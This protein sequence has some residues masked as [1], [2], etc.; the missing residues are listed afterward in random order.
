MFD[1]SNHEESKKTTVLPTE[2]LEEP[3]FSNEAPKK[4]IKK[5]NIFSR[6]FKRNKKEG[7]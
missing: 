4:G 5:W 6:I 3:P 7:K 2:Q 1:N